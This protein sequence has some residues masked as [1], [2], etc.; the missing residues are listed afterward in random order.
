MVTNV[1]VEIVAAGNELLIGDVV[2][3]NSNWLCKKL[4]GIGGYV[5]RVVLVRDDV[6][7][8]A[9]SIQTALSTGAR[10]VFTVGGLGPTADDLTLQ[11]VSKAT[12]RNLTLNPDAF[13]FVRRRY[14]AF[15]QSG[16]VDDATITPS[17]QKMAMLPKG[18][19]PL[20]NNVGAAPG[21]CLSV[22]HAYV[23]SLPG[24]PAELRD[25][26]EGS[27]QP[28]LKAVFGESVFLERV[29]NADCK[30][31][32]VLAPLLQSVAAQH[33]DVYVKS[34]ARRFGSDVKFRITLSKAGS[35]ASQ[36]QQDLDATLQDLRTTLGAAG[37]SVEE[38]E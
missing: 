27:L 26:F 32:S 10:M 1:K 28:V 3:T 22:S 6:E 15:A 11:A 25:I 12:K 24:V 4:T 23:I 5:Q 33:P 16:A 31:E 35:T 14:E 37:I 18:A 30:D 9:K 20:T 38:V 29:L 17:R 21:V 34:R 7:A 13:E 8:I 19:T 36:V 2:D